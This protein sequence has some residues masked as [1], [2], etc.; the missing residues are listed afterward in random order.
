MSKVMSS[1]GLPT[2]NLPF[3]KK[4]DCDCCPPKNECPPHCILQITRHASAGERI[5]VPFMVKNKCG[6]T[7][8]YRIGVRDLKNDD[9]SIAPSQPVLNKHEVTLDAGQS[10]LVLMSIDLLQFSNGNT[11]NAEI[12]L[13]END[14]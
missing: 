13:R 2:F 8:H 9:G 6:A 5:I 3:L 10:E 11:Y 14:I 7:K 4:D 1:I 12:V